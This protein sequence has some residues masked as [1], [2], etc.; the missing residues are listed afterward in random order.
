MARRNPFRLDVIL[1][2]P[3]PARWGVIAAMVI[4][5]AIAL[6]VP[7]M[8]VLMILGMLQANPSTGSP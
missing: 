6:L 2:A 7:I 1:P 5:G 3:G 8:L 4:G